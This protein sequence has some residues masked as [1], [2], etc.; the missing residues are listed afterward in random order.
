MLDGRLLLDPGRYLLEVT[1]EGYEVVRQNLVARP[2][3]K[4]KLRIQ[5]VPPQAEGTP[6]QIAVVKPEPG[7][8]AQEDDGLSTQQWIGI[9]VGAAGVAALG[10]SAAFGLTAMSKA[11]DADCS[12]GTCP[13]QRSKRL[14]DEA[15][16]AGTVSTVTFIAGALVA[17][18]GAV[19]FFVPLSSGEAGERVALQPVIAPDHAGIALGGQW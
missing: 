15:L 13:D 16:D 4:L 3:E 6:G 9:G 5:L 17:A 14:N 18:A 11:D 1:A 19:L 10:V 12:D 7:S 2:R 8:A